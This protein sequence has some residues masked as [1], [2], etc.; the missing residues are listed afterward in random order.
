MVEG[1]PEKRELF[2]A[3]LVAHE[4]R[5]N[6]KARHARSPI[7]NFE[8]EILAHNFYANFLNII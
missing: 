7:R 5:R 4:K 2:N 3:A 6:V 8:N 1:V